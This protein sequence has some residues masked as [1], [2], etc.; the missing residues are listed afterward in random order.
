ML[1]VAHKGHD[2]GGE[3]VILHPCVPGSPQALKK[4]EMEIGRNDII[5]GPVG[6]GWRREAAK[7]SGVERPVSSKYCAT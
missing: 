7:A 6:F 4:A 2:A 3:Y 5:V 1:D